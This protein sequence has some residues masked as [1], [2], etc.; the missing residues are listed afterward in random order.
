MI[1][2]FL[3]CYGFRKPFD[4]ATALLFLL[5]ALFLAVLAATGVAWY[6]MGEL[7]FWS[8]RSIFI[9]YLAATLL[10]A[11]LLSRRHLL[12][13]V[14]LSLCILEFG[15]AGATEVLKQQGWSA[16]L[17]PVDVADEQRFV[18]HPLLQKVPKPGFGGGHGARASHRHT[19]V[20]HN[21]DGFRGEEVRALKEGTK[22]VFAYGGSSTYDVAVDQGKTWVEELERRLGSDYTVLNFG[23]PGYSSQEHVI[24][25][26]FYEDFHGIR[27]RCALY[28]VGWND[29]RNAHIPNLDRGYADSHALIQ[30]D[31]FLVREARIYFARF[32]PLLLMFVRFVQART[33]VI[34]PPPTHGRA[35]PEPAPDPRLEAIYRN[36]IA[37]LEA[38]NRSRG[39]TPIFVGQ[40]LNR[41]RLTEA[42]SFG[43]MP[44]VQERHIWAMQERFNQVLGDQ[45]AA[46]GAHYID[47]GVDAFEDA[48][49]VDEGHFS[50]AGAKKF[51]AILHPQIASVCH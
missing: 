49:F 48:D 30:L 26:A 8:P 34:P 24:Q 17:L 9:T 44:L 32:S 46:L 20:K 10:A 28:Y 3:R 33:S 45:A 11:A 6:L 23:V 47:P 18:Y 15:L 22:L 19:L 41:A 42:R 37:A 39:I 12:S 16:S 25:T 7:T 13:L 4:M 29:I 50:A 40:L 21:S 1:D 31:S 14:L 51:A 38:L 27:P 36:N 35:S 5:N 2:R 43:W